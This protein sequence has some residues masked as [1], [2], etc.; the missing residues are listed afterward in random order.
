MGDMEPGLGQFAN[1][2]IPHHMDTLD[3]IRYPPKPQ[4]GRHRPFVHDPAGCQV[5][6]FTMGYDEK[7]EKTGIFHGSSEKLAV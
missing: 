3:R 2:D 1:G 5:N 6:F 4:S 7:P